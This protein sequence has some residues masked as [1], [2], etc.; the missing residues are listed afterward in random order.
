VVKVQATPPIN[1]V[2]DAIE[3]E[4]ET[5]GP[6]GD[7][8]LDCLTEALF[9]HLVR[10]VSAHVP[11]VG[12]VAGMRDEVVARTLTAVH[13]KPAH[14]WTLDTLARRAGASRSALTQRF[15]AQ[16]GTSPRKYLAQWRVVL[17]T[18]LLRETSL[19]VDEIAEKVGYDST[20]SFSRL[21]KRITGVSPGRYRREGDHARQELYRL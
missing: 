3:H 8:V 10:E 21:F 16:M 11:D 13:T 7:V 18:T 19:S 4:I 9:V 6:G 17:A 15:R 20:A 2:L 1:A 5:M 12:F 14:G